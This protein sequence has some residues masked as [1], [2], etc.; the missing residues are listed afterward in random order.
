VCFTQLH[1]EE[2]NDDEKDE[3]EEGHQ[4]EQQDTTLPPGQSCMLSTGFCKENERALGS[5][6]FGHHGM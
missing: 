5:L 6:D 3:N 2:L 4:C 1:D